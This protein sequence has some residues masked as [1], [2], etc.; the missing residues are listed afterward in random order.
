MVALDPQK[1]TFFCGFS[2]Y[3]WLGHAEQKDEMVP[4]LVE[5]FSFPGCGASQIYTGYTCSF[6]VIE[7]GSLFF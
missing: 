7:V 2:G 3:S 6:A 1:S 5:L 4:C